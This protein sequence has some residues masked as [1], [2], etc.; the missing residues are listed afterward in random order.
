M[1]KKNLQKLKE[2]LKKSKENL[3][4]ELSSFAKKNRKSAGD[5]EAKYPHFNG[6]SGGQKLEEA[7]DEVEEYITLLPI[8][9]SLESKLQATNSALEKIEKGSYGKCEKCKKNI[10]LERLNAC[11]EAKN[12]LHCN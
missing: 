2:A 9:Y 12:C 4:K 3:E 1:D 7:A 6:G 5:W 11:P 10:E 8:E